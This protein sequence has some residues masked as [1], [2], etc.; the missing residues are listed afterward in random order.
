MLVN[1]YVATTSTMLLSKNK[2][3]RIIGLS[4]RKGSSRLYVFSLYFSQSSRLCSV[5]LLSKFVLLCWSKATSLAGVLR[6]LTL[7]SSRMLLW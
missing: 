5:P 1:G 6:Y 3:F 2:K 7:V 4:V